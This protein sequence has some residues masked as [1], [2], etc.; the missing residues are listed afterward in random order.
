MAEYESLL[1]PS[2]MMFRF[3]DVSRVLSNILGWDRSRKLE[4]EKE[5]GVGQRMLVIAGEGDMIVKPY[6]MSRTADEYREARRTMIK[7]ADVSTEAG[8]KFEIVRGG[9]HVQNDVYW[10]ECAQRIFLFLEQL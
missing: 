1:W 3:T 4:G 5:G 7:D 10:E 8:I 2:Q 6:L 9:H